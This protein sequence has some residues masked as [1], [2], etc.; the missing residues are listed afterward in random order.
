MLIPCVLSPTIFNFHNLNEIEQKLK[1]NQIILLFRTI[2]SRG[3]V[4]FDDTDFLKS[5]IIQ[6]INDIDNNNIKKKLKELLKNLYKNF[7]REEIEVLPSEK[8]IQEY[9]RY[10]ASTV[11][12][13]D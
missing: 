6:N 9:C 4:L 8:S 10:F 1:L 2:Q 5:E 12:N 3:I 11:I 7:K 13:E